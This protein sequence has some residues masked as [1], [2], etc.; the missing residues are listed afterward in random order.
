MN[1]KYIHDSNR[2]SILHSPCTRTDWDYSVSST[3]AFDAED[4]VK[5]RFDF[6]VAMSHKRLSANVFDNNNV[7]V[8]VDR[9]LPVTNVDFWYNVLSAKAYIADS[10]TQQEL[11]SII[12]SLR[13]RWIRGDG[14]VASVQ[15]GAGV[16][17]FDPD[18]IYWDGEEDDY[19]LHKFNTAKT[20]AGLPYNKKFVPVQDGDYGVLVTPHVRSSLYL[21]N[22]AAQYPLVV[23][24]VDFDA[25]YCL[26]P[27]SNSAPLGRMIQMA[28]DGMTGASAFDTQ[29]QNFMEELS[30]M[31]D[32]LSVNN[33]MKPVGP[34]L[35][36]RLYCEI[37][38]SSFS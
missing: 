6:L 16:W 36:D 1:F 22:L 27:R 11:V 34:T 14:I 8:V 18:I 23:H 35:F 38:R 4:A 30:T 26:D 25:S 33:Y 12:P 21:N 37:N 17:D 29:M 15:P 2:L 32:S 13:S 5:G 9:V 3:T 24:P 31:I 28:E 10:K 20:E 7:I 19:L